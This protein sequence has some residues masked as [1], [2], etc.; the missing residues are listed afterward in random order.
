MGIFCVSSS[1]RHLIII[2]I[3]LWAAYALLR[4]AL[5]WKQE[6]EKDLLI[7][8]TPW[9]IYYMITNVQTQWK[10]YLELLLVLLTCP[11]QQHLSETPSWHGLFS[12]T[13]T[14]NQISSPCLP[15]FQNLLLP[16][17]LRIFYLRCCHNSESNPRL[18]LAF[19]GLLNNLRDYNTSR[20]INSTGQVTILCK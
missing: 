15:S 17:A 5:R 6:P 14:I 11:P 20:S 13:P 12:I 8:L 9:S 16:S 3:S 18:L 10:L 1:L 7:C 19:K 2:P 4:R